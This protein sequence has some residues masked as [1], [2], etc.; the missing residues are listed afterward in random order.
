MGTPALRGMTCMCRWNTTWP[1]APS[2]NCWTV[3]PSAENTFMAALAI[4]CAATAT[5]ARSSGLTSSRLR[6]G[7]F[8]STSVWPGA[9]GMMSRN[10]STLS[11]S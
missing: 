4:F 8:G 3:M 5:A 10:A 6:A 11:S 1:P 2:L 7:A 9:R